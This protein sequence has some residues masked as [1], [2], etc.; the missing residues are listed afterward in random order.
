MSRIEEIKKAIDQV[1]SN[2]YCARELDTVDS[3]IGEALE[4]VLHNADRYV[5]VYLTIQDKIELIKQASNYPHNFTGQMVED[6]EWVLG[7]MN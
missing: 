3:D 5:E 1:L 4:V 7:L 6:L 2:D